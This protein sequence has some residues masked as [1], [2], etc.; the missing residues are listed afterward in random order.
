M[1]TA[2]ED[3]F[4]IQTILEDYD[5]EKY[6]KSKQCWVQTNMVRERVYLCT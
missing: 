5:A 3:F 2:L 4:D 1:T 6:G